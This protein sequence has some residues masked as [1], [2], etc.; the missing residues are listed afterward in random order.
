MT[1][2]NW[3]WSLLVSHILIVIWLN[4]YG[5]GF[6]SEDVVCNGPVVLVIYG[7]WMLVIYLILGY[8]SYDRWVLD[9]W[10]WSI[11][12]M[13]FG[14][15]SLMV[16][17]CWLDIMVPRYCSH[18]SWMLTIYMYGEDSGLIRGSHI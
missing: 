5:I 6:W 12:H 17:G 4:I 8:W 14:G 16:H 7:H 1:I 10:S 15:W 9:M 3:S 11:G 2:L 13:V 18:G